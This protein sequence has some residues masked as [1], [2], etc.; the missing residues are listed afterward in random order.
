MDSSCKFL[1][2]VSDDADFPG[3]TGGAQAHL[4]RHSML[5]WTWKCPVPPSGDLLNKSYV[6]HRLARLPSPP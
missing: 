5:V 3:P 6:S 4:L 1:F 2:T